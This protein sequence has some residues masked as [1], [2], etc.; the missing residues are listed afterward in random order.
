MDEFLA[1]L[2]LVM[3]IEGVLPF[4][5]PGA[6]R[7]YMLQM[8]QMDDRTLRITGLVSMLVGLG[9]LYLVR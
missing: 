6:M 1:A 5:S 8:L 7:K 2:A 4:L 3:V 9:L